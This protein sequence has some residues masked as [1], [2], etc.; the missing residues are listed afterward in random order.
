[1]QWV[2]DHI[3]SSG[4]PMCA[5]GNSGG[6]VQIAYALSQYGLGSGTAPILS[7]VEPTSG[8]EFSRI[9]YGCAPENAFTACAICGFGTLQE[10]YG[11]TI[12]ANGVDPA[13]T[14]NINGTGPCSYDYKHHTTN[15]EL[16]H[17]DSILSDKFS[18]TTQFTFTTDI[19][20]A[21]GG[22]DANTAALPEG[23]LW[24]S[25][26]KSPT[27]IVCVPTAEHLLPSSNAGAQQIED[28]LLSYC[29]LQPLH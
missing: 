23:L 15:A 22:L 4:T 17:N 8:P 19:H 27:A 9:D 12:A 5:T 11:G 25:M 14:G 20:F 1:M 6:A 16:F 3:L 18:T 21:F 13:Y 2:H 26:I 10:S 28:D 29:K 24:A 7:M